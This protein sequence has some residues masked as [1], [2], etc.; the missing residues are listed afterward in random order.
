MKTK[1]F[2]KRYLPSG[3]ALLMVMIITAASVIILAGT[4]SRTYTVA[5]LNDRS[6]QLVLCQNAAEAAVEKAFARMQY[7][8]QFNGGPGIVASS[9]GSY[10]NSYPNANE[11]GFWGNFV[12]SDSVTDNKTCVYKYGTNYT[13]PLPQAYTN[14]NT[15][16]APIY[17]IVS[18]ARLRNGNSSVVGTAQEDVM[19]ALV[20]LSTYAIFYNGLLEF[21]TCAPMTVNGVVHCNTNIYVGAGGGATLTFNAMVTSSGKITAPANNG[22]SWSTPTTYDPNNWQTT[23]KGNYANGVPTVQLAIPMTNTHSIIDMPV[24]NDWMTTAGAQRLYNQAQVILLVSNSTVTTL[25]HT[26]PDGQV[27]GGDPNA[28]VTT[29]DY[30][31][32]NMSALTNLPFLSLTN[33][34]RDIREGTTNVTTQIDLGKYSTWLNGNPGNKFGSTYY[35]LILY[36]ADQRTVGAKQLAVVRLTNGIA[37]PQNIGLGFSLATPNPL[38]VWGNYNET[39]AAF[40]GTTNTSGGTIPSALMSDAMTIL[41]SQWNDRLS[42]TSAYANGAANWDAAS[43]TTVNAAILTGVVPS[44]GS[45]NM[46]FSGGV[47]NL[48]RL[49]EDWS[50]S[51]LWLNTS[52]INLFNSTRAKGQFLNPGIYYAPPTRKFSYDQNFSNPNKVPPGIPNALVALRYNWAVPPPGVTSYNVIP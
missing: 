14:R 51:T 42:L 17:R 2:L 33:L 6:N 26:A 3:Y 21:S 49:L 16:N 36:V 11:D 40:L 10:A 43:A 4:L 35:P 44:T 31:S 37:P 5:K 20:P 8:F 45:D 13:G 39:N 32:T 27:P 46:H 19:L 9:L 28:V 24:T 47:H 52:I 23:F 50:S 15:A 30:S 12:F 48:P 38:Y 29:Y 34:F 18:N 41:S 25:L 7:D 22:A 1:L